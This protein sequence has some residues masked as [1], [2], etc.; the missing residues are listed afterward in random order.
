VRSIVGRPMHEYSVAS[1]LRNS[2]SAEATWPLLPMT[3]TIGTVTNP[4]PP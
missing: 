1:V 2:A 3:R 4:I